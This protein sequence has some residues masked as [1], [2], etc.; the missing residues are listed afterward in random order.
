MIHLAD[1]NNNAVII[2]TKPGIA[3]TPT[4]NRD[5]KRLL[6]G[7]GNCKRHVLGRGGFGDKRRATLAGK[8]AA[9]FGVSGIGRQYNSTSEC[10]F[11][12]FQ[13][14]HR[15]IIAE[16][17]RNARAGAVLGSGSALAPFL[18]LFYTCSMIKALIFDCFGVF[19]TDPV[20]A[21]MRDPATPPPKAQALHALDEQAARGMLDKDGFIAQ[22]ATMLGITQNDAEQ[23]FFRSKDRNQ[24]LVKLVKELRKT[25][26]VGMLSNIGGDMMDGFF[27][28]QER[29]QLFDAVI[30]SGDVK[31]AKPDR[32]IFELMC[33]RLHV[34]LSEAVMIDDMQ[35]TCDAV[36]TFGMQSVCYKNIQQLKAELATIL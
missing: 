34:K 3:V 35:S 9:G 19:Y 31:M 11:E 25:Y 22:A 13:C 30:L 27:S 26:A 21:Y 33:E 32:P 6:P 7:I 14:L 24:P 36:K 23:R 18:V 4:A 10:F 5:N 15:S 12:L 16:L 29:R 17:T 28:L 2:S 8:Y 1:I 20:F